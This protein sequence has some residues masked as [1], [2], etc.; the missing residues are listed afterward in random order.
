MTASIS[1]LL[2][3][4]LTVSSLALGWPLWAQETRT[5]STKTT[6]TR[7]LKLLAEENYQALAQ[8]LKDQSRAKSAKQKPRAL[9]RRLRL[10][11]TLGRLALAFKKSDSATLKRLHKQQLTTLKVEDVP[12]L[13]GLVGVCQAALRPYARQWLKVARLLARREP[14]NL[15]ECLTYLAVED[16]LVRRYAT[17]AMAKKLARLRQRVRKGGRLVKTE[18]ALLSNSLL[19]SAMIDQCEREPRSSAVDRLGA[20]EL[21]LNTD[22]ARALH[23]LVLIE[24]P[25]LERLERAVAAG[26]PGLKEALAAV[27]QAVKDR[28]RRVPQSLWHDARAQRS[29]RSQAP[30]EAKKQ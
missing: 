30:K 4:C 3:A 2:F 22:N 12:L 9:T 21:A 28:L 27:K 5:K 1:R 24:E 25:S 14:E 6:E 23:V 17:S 19:I 16:V 8:L 18:R 13:K 29:K 10:I 26:R 15:S 20:L 7:A 11:Q